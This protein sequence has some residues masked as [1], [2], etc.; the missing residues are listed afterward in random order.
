MK[1]LSKE[2]F[3]KARLF[4]KTQAQDIDLAMFEYFFEDKPIDKVIDILATYQNEDGGF[5]KLDYDFEYPYSCLKHTESACRYIFALGIVPDSNPMIQKLIPYLIQNYNQD[6]GEWNNH[7][8]PA[9]NDYPHAPWWGYTEP[10]IYHPKDRADLINHYDPNT[11]SSLAGMLVKYKSLVPQHFLD[12]VMGV[13]IE[14]INS[15]YGFGQYGMMSDIYFINSLGDAA[16]KN[17]LLATLIGDGSLLSML[18]ENWGTEN[19]VKLCHWIDSPFHPHYGLYKEAVHMNLGFLIECQEEDGAWSPNWS[20]GEADVWERVNRRLK[21]LLT[22]T[23]LRALQKY[24]CIE[25]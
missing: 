12:T 22:F 14:K 18:D 9:V 5:G 2:Q 15:G 23:F 24:N 16:M 6:T 4:M 13:V 19:A 11:N 7:L 10:E 1:I 21:G 20:W 25:V 8:V 17:K 3:Q